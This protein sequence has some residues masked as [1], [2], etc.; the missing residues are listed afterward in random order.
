M[1]NIVLSILNLLRKL[2]PSRFKNSF[3]RALF[4]LSIFVSRNSN[5]VERIN[6]AMS[7]IHVN[8]YKLAKEI[9]EE[10]AKN[11]ITDIDLPLY[12][13]LIE[14]LELRSKNDVVQ[15]QK[16]QMLEK[17]EEMNNE[18]KS[19]EIYVPGDFWNETGQLHLEL[20]KM[21]GVE[22][23]KRTVSHH[24]QNWLMVSRDDPQVK[25]LFSLWNEHKSLQPWI[26]T[27]ENPDH[28]GFNP[29]LILPKYPLADKDAREV[30]RL[31]VG[32]LWEYVSKNDKESLLQ[33]LS[34]L[35][36]GNPI[37]IW[38]KGK[39][40]S[41]DIAHSVRERGKLFEATNLKGDESLTIGEL[42]AGHGRLAEI[43]GKT[44]NFRH[45]IFDITP[46]LYV[47]QWYVKEI[48][49]NEKIFEFRSFDNFNDIQEELDQCRFAFFTSNQIEKIPEDYLDIFINFKSL[50]EMQKRQVENFL[51][52]IGRITSKTFFSSQQI[53]S[54]NPVEAELFTKESFAM[55]DKWRLDVDEVDDVHPMYFNQIWNKK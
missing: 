51:H 1:K 26:N 35:D 16:N 8:D 42:G 49:P 24:Y 21:Y 14:F 31:A 30:Y 11:D 46:A 12:L 20:L 15:K 9:L 29:N 23:F 4:W 52:H 22:N 36:T 28:I 45:I 43:F 27:I 6:S 33:N 37:R 25:Q 55:N 40:I 53:V 54:K 47:S 44:S 10:C 5:T 41:S 50:A 7:K 17:I 13:R 19:K 2:I 32:L 48:F 39:S 34:E 18:I 38:R 3:S